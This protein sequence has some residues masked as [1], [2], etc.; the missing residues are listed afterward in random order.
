MVDIPDE[1]IE[2][3][4]KRDC[5][6]F[7]GAGMSMDAGLLGG[8]QLAEKLF[9]YLQNKGYN[10]PANFTLPRVAEDFKAYFGRNKLEEVIRD[11]IIKSMENCDPTAYKLL[12]QVEPLPKIII[13]TNYDQLLE[14]YLGEKNYIPIFN[15]K[16]ISKYS[17]SSPKTILFKIHG[18]INQLENAVIT[19]ED[20]RKYEE[21]YP[22]IWTQL[23]SFLQYMPI[24]FLGFSIEDPHLRE[25]YKKIKEQ[26]GE[27]MPPAYAITPNNEVQIR[28][29]ELGVKHIKMSAREF[30]KNLL[31]KMKREAYYTMP[32]EIDVISN[33]NPFSIYSSEYFPVVGW[34]KMVNDIFVPP[35][36]FA[37][38]A[39]P[40]NTI[41][42]GHRGSG[43]TMI[44]KYLSYEAQRKRKFKENW[45]KN[46][47]GVY[48]KF[49]PTIVNTTTK[50]F[51]KGSERDWIKYFS[52][53]TNLLIGEEIL[54]ILE[55]AKINNEINIDSEEELVST[56]IYLFFSSVP[57][58]T[59]ENSLKNLQLMIKRF[60]NELAQKHI[61]EY[62]LPVDFIE[63]TVSLIK[64]HV[65]E[66]S[67][68]DFYIL[69]D[70]YDNL[71]DDQQRV[72]NTL[73]KDRVF[74]FKVGVKLFGMIY[75]DITGKLLEKNNDYVYVNTDRFDFDPHS[76]LYKKY[77]KFAEDVANQ[78]LKTYGY[79]NT[80][81]ELLPAETNEERAGFENGDY[82]GFKNIVRLSSG[83]I[84]DFLELCKDMIYYSNPWV[85]NEKKDKLEP[86][87]PNIQNT[88]IKIHSNIL[89]VNIDMI[90]GI[91]NESGKARSE[92]LRILID[93]LALIFKNILKGSQSKELR[94]VSGFQLK[95]IDNLNTTAKNA[96]NDGVSIRLLQIPYNLRIPQNPTKY[97]V[98]KRYKFHRLLCPR[99]KLSIAERWPKEIDAQVFNEIFKKPEYAV[100]EITQYFIKNIPL[101]ITTRLS[102]FEVIQNEKIHD[103]S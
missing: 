6:I 1:I 100:K 79:N 9:T 71:D 77:E 102:D 16:A 80:I 44:L 38:I 26:M 21:K 101:K 33:S 103:E 86:V 73:I 93:S 69:L 70:E 22:R 35:I 84:R 96:L 19:E 66:W 31:K 92:N 29:K 34:E 94:T 23:Q 49:R 30:L 75:E 43:K 98:H 61:L 76:P 37:V 53:Y 67:T 68:K 46:Y 64:E 59:G 97:A 40:G 42:E 32:F 3:I 65:K 51:F 87:P 91:D 48:I 57:S 24:I 74:S 2:W 12:S 18:D 4:L 13:T 85:V 25:I 55:V 78:R 41:I 50:E 17:I 14:K 54:R 82:S 95:N 89:Y 60:R 5:I 11:E 45:D 58:L 28:L 8:Q 72:V 36:N 56:I 39:E 47:V 27:R 81:N 62:D 99:F 15:D 10:K 63:E 20:I 90:P 83:I 88:V 52:T 7:I